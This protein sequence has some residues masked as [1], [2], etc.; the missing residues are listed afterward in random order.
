[1]EILYDFTYLKTSSTT[2]EISPHMDQSVDTLSKFIVRKIV[3]QIFYEKIGNT[4]IIDVT[5]PRRKVYHH[6]R[7]STCRQKGRLNED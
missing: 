4:H 7:S 2:Y 6:L 1:M 3:S 5:S